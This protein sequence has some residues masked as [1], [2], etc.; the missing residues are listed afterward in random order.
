MS[1]VLYVLAIVAAFAAMGGLVA[2]CDR[3]AGR[4]EDPF[5]PAGGEPP[6]SSSSSTTPGAGVRR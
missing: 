4:G 3:V 2:A 5:A 1:D 6:S